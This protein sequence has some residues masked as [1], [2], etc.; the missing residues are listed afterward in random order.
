MIDGIEELR[1]PL[2]GR[3]A[4]QPATSLPGTVRWSGELTD[5]DVVPGTV[6]AGPTACPALGRGRIQA[7]G[8]L[9]GWQERESAEAQL[10]LFPMRHS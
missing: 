6:G 7:A 2:T 3:G 8:V 1:A 10:K 5:G 4:H 9:R